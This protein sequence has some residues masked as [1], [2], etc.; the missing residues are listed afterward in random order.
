MA[1]IF[2]RE[3]LQKLKKKKRKKK[4]SN[5]VRNQY[6]NFRVTPDEYELLN[7]K[8][9]MSGLLKQDYIIQCLLNS[10]VKVKPDYRLADK[11]AKEIFQLARVIKKYGQLDDQEQEI[12]IFILEIYEELKKEKSL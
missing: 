8:V 3:S 12:L 7:K 2:R 9:E 10:G 4:E 6:V 5:R 1:K 11:I